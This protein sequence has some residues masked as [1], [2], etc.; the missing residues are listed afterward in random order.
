MEGLFLKVI[1]FTQS[2]IALV[3]SDS[4]WASGP[5]WSGEQTTL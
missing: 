1:Y 5:Q 2:N 4:R 3:R